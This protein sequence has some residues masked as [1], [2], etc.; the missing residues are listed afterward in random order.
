VLEGFFGFFDGVRFCPYTITDQ[1]VAYPSNVFGFDFDFKGIG[2]PR[3]DIG[4]IELPTA[5]T[6]FGAITGCDELIFAVFLGS[7]CC[8]WFNRPRGDGFEVQG[9]PPFVCYWIIRF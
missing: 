5:T 8:A 9:A 2:L 3:L 1:C 6:C 7:C 4:I